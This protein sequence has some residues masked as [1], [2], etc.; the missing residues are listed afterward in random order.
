MRVFSAVLLPTLL[1][2]YRTQYIQVSLRL[3]SFLLLLAIIIMSED[4]TASENYSPSGDVATIEPIE[5]ETL[6][7][8]EDDGLLLGD[9]EGKNRRGGTADP[10][11][12]FVDGNEEGEITIPYEYPTGVIHV[13]QL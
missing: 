1:S 10:V 13:D 5:E 4:I 3:R 7:V 12:R 2:L 8:G 9:D 6:E 11:G